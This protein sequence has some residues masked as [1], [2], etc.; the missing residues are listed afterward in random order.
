MTYC[1]HSIIG[2]M[3]VLLGLT[4]R[5]AHTQ[6]KHQATGQRHVFT[7]V[8]REPA[9]T[10]FQ[11]KEE[12]VGFPS[13]AKVAVTTSQYLDGLTSRQEDDLL[14]RSDVVPLF[15]RLQAIGW[16]VSDAREIE[17]QLLTDSDW[18][19]RTL[20]TTKG[21][22]FMRDMASFPGG[23]DRLDRMRQLP[24]GKQQL[25]GLINSPG[26][27]KL[28]DYLTN[29]PQGRR[30][31][32]DLTSSRGR[33]AFNTPTQ[34]L[35]TKADV[36]KQIKTSYAA[37]AA[38][39]LQE[40]STQATPKPTARPTSIAPAQEAPSPLESQPEEEAAPP[41]SSDAPEDE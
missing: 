27:A 37:E 7:K 22:R 6:E 11:A 34:R 14:S 33:G 12:P 28:I 19:V 17:Q 20:R 21:T 18:L 40:A 15:R 26:G 3:A 23:Y 4:P 2:L 41:E 10:A 25:A 35:Y 5:T 29:T 31:G 39:R 13:F 9:Q 8:L 16:K 32:A 36:F 1:K 24:H 30:T 38:R